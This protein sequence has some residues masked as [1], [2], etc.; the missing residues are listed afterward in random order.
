M[1]PR[2]YKCKCVSTR[3]LQLGVR[4]FPTDGIPLRSYL[5]SGA[6][7]SHHLIY[8]TVS[9]HLIYSLPISR[10]QHTKTLQCSEMHCT[11]LHFIALHC[12]S[13]HFTALQITLQNSALQ[14]TIS[15]HTLQ[16]TLWF[17]RSQSPVYQ[18]LLY[19]KHCSL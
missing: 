16:N 15:N 4:S 11:S 17:L 19:S 12:T 9:Y 3:V 1:L 6:A 8:S 10:L 13:L 5:D 7:L 2:C 18:I 14:F